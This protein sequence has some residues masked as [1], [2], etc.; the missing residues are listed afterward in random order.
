M[1]KKAREERKEADEKAAAERSASPA[2]GTAKTEE[3]VDEEK[4]VNKINTCE[5]SKTE[6]DEVPPEL[7]T[8]D[9][10]K[11]KA[12]QA[13]QSEKEKTQRQ[14]YDQ[15]RNNIAKSSTEAE[16]DEG[17]TVEEVKDEPEAQPAQEETKEDPNKDVLV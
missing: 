14:L 15:M 13:A 16:A 10:D 9:A 3:V 5:E 6:E 2:E 7:E 4:Q 11:L 1:I 12:E 17:C 8:V